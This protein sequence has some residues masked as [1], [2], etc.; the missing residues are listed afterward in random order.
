M[1]I[2]GYMNPVIASIF[3]LGHIRDSVHD[4]SSPAIIANAHSL[5][6]LEAISIKNRCP[7]RVPAHDTE[8][9]PRVFSSK[10]DHSLGAWLYAARL[11]FSNIDFEIVSRLFLERAAS[12]SDS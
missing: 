12:A 3:G 8:K 9:P 10:C 7:E 6:I 4:A 11:I 5:F 1:V 2:E